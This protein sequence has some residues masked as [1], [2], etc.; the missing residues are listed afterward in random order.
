MFGPEL[1][2]KA[3]GN[4]AWKHREEGSQDVHRGARGSTHGVSTSAWSGWKEESGRREPLR[5]SSV[6]KAKL[7]AGHTPCNGL[8]GMSV[9]VS[10]TPMSSTLC[11]P[12]VLIQGHS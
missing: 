4:L 2:H 9:G 11:V 10:S 12:L 1:K 8:F 7:A 6:V 3:L 5:C